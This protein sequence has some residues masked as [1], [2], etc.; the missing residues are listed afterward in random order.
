M[1]WWDN[2]VQ[3]VPTLYDAFTFEAHDETC[4]LRS[5]RDSTPKISDPSLIFLV[6]KGHAIGVSYRLLINKIIENRL[7]EGPISKKNSHR[8]FFFG[9]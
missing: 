3:R 4:N 5:G 9:S 1:A 7:N 2:V 8:T 6:H